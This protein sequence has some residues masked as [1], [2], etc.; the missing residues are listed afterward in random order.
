MLAWLR[1]EVM[2]AKA[3]AKHSC[4]SQT[5]LVTLESC[6]CCSCTADLSVAPSLLSCSGKACAA[7][8]AASLLQQQ[9]LGE[10]RFSYLSCQCD[11]LCPQEPGAAWCTRSCMLSS[12]TLQL[13]PH[14]CLTC[15]S[16]TVHF[17][18]RRPAPSRHH[19]ETHHAPSGVGRVGASL[20]SCQRC[21]SGFNNVHP[22]CTTSSACPSNLY[23]PAGHAPADPHPTCHAGQPM[24]PTLRLMSG[25]RS[26]WERQTSRTRARTSLRWPAWLPPSPATP[27]QLPWTWLSSDCR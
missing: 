23:M 22:A 5:L 4:Q 18:M 8:T 14:C 7:C 1:W 26:G 15:A 27:L 6:P 24:L 13:V 10:S 16:L 17:C 3:E 25:P 11:P 2:A 19:A 12:S 21:P 20:T 9:E